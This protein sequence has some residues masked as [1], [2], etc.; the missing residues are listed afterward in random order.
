M[1]KKLKKR[2][3]KKTKKVNQLKKNTY[4]QNLKKRLKNSDNEILK[5]DLKSG[6]QYETV[7]FLDDDT[8]E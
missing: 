7:N 6:Y 8:D 1:K 4:Q 2:I 3:K 5:I